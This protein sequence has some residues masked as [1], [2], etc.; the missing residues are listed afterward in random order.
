VPTL[1]APELGIMLVVLGV[2]CALP[3][4]GAVALVVMLIRDRTRG[5]PNGERRADKRALLAR[6][7][8]RA[9]EPTRGESLMSRWRAHLPWLIAAGVLTVMVLLFLFAPGVR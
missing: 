8:A 7:E 4:A 6:T 1:D 2:V 3:L 9:P 5:R